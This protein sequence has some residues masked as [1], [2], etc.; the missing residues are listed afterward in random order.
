MMK[1]I[2]QKLNDAPPTSLTG[3]F[4]DVNNRLQKFSDSLGSVAAWH[5]REDSHGCTAAQR[6]LA[7][8]LNMV[9]KAAAASPQTSVETLMV[10]LDQVSDELANG[11]IIH[12][13]PPV[14]KNLDELNY[15]AGAS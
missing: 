7:L 14:G 10:K 9:L 1:E 13:A 8:R 2:H 15:S 4:E 6:R 12:A 3:H 11:L 5:E